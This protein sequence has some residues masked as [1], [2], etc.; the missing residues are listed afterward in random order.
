MESSAILAV[1]SYHVIAHNYLS[2]ASGAGDCPGITED[3]SQVSYTNRVNGQRLRTNRG[4]FVRVTNLISIG[5]SS[6]NIDCSSSYRTYRT[7]HSNLSRGENLVDDNVLASFLETMDLARQQVSSGNYIQCSLR[8]SDIRRQL[9]AGEYHSFSKEAVLY[10]N[11]S[12]CSQHPGQCKQ[13]CVT[14][15][16]QLGNHPSKR[17]PRVVSNKVTGS[18]DTTDRWAYLSTRHNCNLLRN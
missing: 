5:N 9:E 17:L 12:V 18:K 7:S 16:H 11:S 6:R 10:G 4:F 13:R 2:F 1:S 3:L 14:I 8:I 15:R